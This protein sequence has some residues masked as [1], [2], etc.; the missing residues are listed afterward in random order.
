MN[1]CCTSFLVSTLS[2]NNVF[3][4]MAKN[5]IFCRNIRVPLQYNIRLLNNYILRKIM[6]MIKHN[7]VNLPKYLCLFKSDFEKWKNFPCLANA[8]IAA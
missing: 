3:E 1:A 5:D 7:I 6:L 4:P 2:F 8:R